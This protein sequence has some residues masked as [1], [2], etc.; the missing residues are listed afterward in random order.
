MHSLQHKVHQILLVL[1]QN[2]FQFF[3]SEINYE[4]TVVNSTG[5]KQMLIDLAGPINLR[6]A[7]GWH[8]M[9]W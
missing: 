3:L 2:V 5:Q 9:G 1:F 8:S 6:S 4:T 7:E